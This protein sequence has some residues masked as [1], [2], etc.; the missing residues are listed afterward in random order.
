MLNMSTKPRWGRMLGTRRRATF[1][2]VGHVKTSA[3][4]LTLGVG[5]TS[6]TPP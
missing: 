5:A 4:K 6:S 2:N 3:L 1:R